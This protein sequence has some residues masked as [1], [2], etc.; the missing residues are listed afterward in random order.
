MQKLLLTLWAAA[1]PVL[2]CAQPEPQSISFQLIQNRPFIEVTVNGVSGFFLVDSGGVHGF[3]REFAEAAG[4]EFTDSLMIHGAGNGSQMSWRSG[5]TTLSINNT[6]VSTTTRSP[7]IIDLNPLRD[8]LGLPFLDGI[9][10]VQLFREYNVAID[11]PD[12]TMILYPKGTYPTE[13]FETIPFTLYRNQIPMIS[14]EVDGVFGDFTIDTGDKSTLTIFEPFLENMPENY[15][16]GEVNI[17]GYGVG[18]PIYGQEFVIGEV[19]LGDVISFLKVPA[20]V[21]RNEKGRWSRT[22]HAGN[23]GGGLLTGHEVIFDF[24]NN[25]FLISRALRND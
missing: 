7:I 4:L 10:G 23:I 8:S 6:D 24:E 5:Q 17:T 9:I 15:Q 12:R 19:H 14:M 2:G 11:Y 1:I 13:G 16:L 20:R 25:L 18:G 22:T 3:N 21:P